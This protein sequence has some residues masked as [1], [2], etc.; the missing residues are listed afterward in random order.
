MVRLDRLINAVSEL[1]SAAAR[2]SDDSASQYVAQQAFIHARA[3]Y[4]RAETL[5]EYFT[6]VTAGEMNGPAIPRMA[7]DEP[8]QI[9]TPPD[10]FQVIEEMLFP[11]VNVKERTALSTAVRVL[12]GHARR[13]KTIAEVSSFTDTALFDAMRLELTRVMSLGLAGFDSP[14]AGQSAGEAAEA[15]AGVRLVFAPYARGLA[16][17]DL[18]L[19]QDLDER[20]LMAESWLR[21]QSA[22]TPLDQLTFLTTQGI[23]LARVLQESVIALGIPLPLEPRLWRATAA[24][25]FDDGAWDAWAFAPARDPRATAEVTLLG[26]RLFNDPVL[27]GDGVRSCASCHN[28]EKG[29]VDQ[30]PRNSAI[31]GSGVTLRNTPTL[32]NAALQTGQFYDLRTTYLEDQVAQVIQ[33]P[34]EMNG[35]LKDAATVVG[36]NAWYRAAFARAFDSSSDSVVT[37]RQIQIALASYVRSLVR[38][39]APF[40]R[41]MRGDTT[42]MNEAAR[43][44]FNTFMGKAGCGSCHFAPLFGG[45]LPPVFA[46]T[47]LE[48][49]GV[50]DHPDTVN[51]TIDPDVGAFSVTR[52]S[53]HQYAFKAPSLRN[54]AITAPYMHNGV[55]QT[56]EEVVDF[57]D[58]GGGVG[59]GI[60]LPNQTLPATPLMLTAQEKSDLI[61]FLEALTDVAAPETLRIQ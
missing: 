45:P 54:S 24:S 29:F 59:I 20:F 27:S 5:I 7:P 51:A 55:Y 44:G 58:R 9:I 4:K 11:Q 42:A 12:G 52:M 18:S 14:V 43:R 57:Y 60:D 1:D 22:E 10:G 37:E 40:D 33:N 50:P 8:A 15:I 61:S 47:D 28:P 2:V 25:P 3:A 39:D 46:G 17:V 19:A 56:L 36:E 35:S 16:L 13:A 38:L 41:Y 21:E 6:P 53:V 32:I 26:A 49:I 30:L 48:V 31:G 23:P 34:H